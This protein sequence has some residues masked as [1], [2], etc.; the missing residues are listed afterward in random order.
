MANKMAYVSV[1]YLYS[2]SPA[3]LHLDNNCSTKEFL[4]AVEKHMDEELSTMLCP[5]DDIE[6]II[7]EV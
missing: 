7:N 6:I 2:F 5:Y 1:T 3:E 4:A